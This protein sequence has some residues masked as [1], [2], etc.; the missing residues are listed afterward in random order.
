[1]H[2]RISLKKDGIS[3]DRLGYAVG[4]I[5]LAVQDAA[6]LLLHVSLLLM[7]EGS[8]EPAFMFANTAS[9]RTR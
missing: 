1:M 6:F 7:G 4:S 5:A 2:L 8:G 9:I 3:G